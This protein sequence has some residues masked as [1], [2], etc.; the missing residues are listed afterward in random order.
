MNFKL[1]SKIVCI[2]KESFLLLLFEKA[3]MYDQNDRVFKVRALLYAR[4]IQ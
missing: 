1:S 3:M 2:L 4:G